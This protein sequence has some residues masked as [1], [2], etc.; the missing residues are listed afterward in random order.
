MFA[1]LLLLKPIPRI[2]FITLSYIFFSCF[3]SVLLNI[4]RQPPRVL[5]VSSTSLHLANSELH[6]A[7]V[8]NVSLQVKHVWKGI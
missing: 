8:Q 7:T 4:F 5:R 2:N 1:I 3:L 6:T